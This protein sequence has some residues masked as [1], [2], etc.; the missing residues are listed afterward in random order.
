NPGGVRTGSKILRARLRGP[1]MLRYYPP[2]LNLRS[3][4]ML[5]RELEGDLWR[6]VV[7]W[8]ERQRLA[9]LDKAKHYGKNP[10]KKGQGRRAA[11]KGK[12]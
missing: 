10:P 4:N 12:R 6:D 11:V 8:N 3:V 2:T 9:D 1:S 7:D 5:G